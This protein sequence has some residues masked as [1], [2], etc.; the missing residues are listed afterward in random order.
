MSHQ[1]HLFARQTQDTP[2]TERAGFG[3]GTKSDSRDTR[4]IGRST[5]P[6]D[7]IALP[8]GIASMEHWLDLNA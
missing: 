5:L 3:R 1:L 7:E 4:T 6:R 2:E 8:S